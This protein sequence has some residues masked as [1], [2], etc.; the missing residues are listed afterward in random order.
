MAGAA[1]QPEVGWRIAAAS[2]SRVNAIDFVGAVDCSLAART[3]PTISRGNF[4]L[5]ELRPTPVVGL[6][7]VWSFTQG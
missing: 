4:L 6:A 7:T 1:Q 2:A 3:R 5:H